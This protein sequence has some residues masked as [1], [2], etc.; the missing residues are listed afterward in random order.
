VIEKKYL[1]NLIKWTRKIAKIQ[2]NA[3]HQEFLKKLIDSKNCLDQILLNVRNLG[4]SWDAPRA[5]IPL[6]TVESEEDEEFMMVSNENQERDAD[7]EVIQ[8]FE[9]SQ[10]SQKVSDSLKDSFFDDE[11][12]ISEKSDS[13]TIQNDRRMSNEKESKTVIYLLF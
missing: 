6:E 11:C 10:S 8:D 5:V 2:M 13:E 12:V 4:I 9:N 1:P 7:T 3:N